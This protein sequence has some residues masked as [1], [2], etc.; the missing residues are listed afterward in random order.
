MTINF[1]FALMLVLFFMLVL[2]T[3]LV[4]TLKH[5]PKILKWCTAILLIVYLFLLFIGTA[6]KISLK[7]N[8]LKISFNFTK[9]WFSLYFLWFNFS[10]TNVLINLFLLFPVGYVVF[11]FSKN[12]P[13]LKT[14]LLA[15]SISIIVEI[16]QWVLP[17]H[18]NTELSDIL[19]NVISGFI[20]A[21]YCKL[22]LTLGAFKTNKTPKYHL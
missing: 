9:D 8:T 21:I 4:F 15:L 13:F 20:S 3:T 12:H 14:I 7:S 6:G 22:L 17:I 16:Y 5:K 11:T 1:Y 10:K 19:F 18:R 2:P